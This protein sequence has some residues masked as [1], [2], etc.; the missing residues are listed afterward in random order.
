MLFAKRL[1]QALTGSS[2]SGPPAQVPMAHAKQMLASLLTMAWFVEA[3]DPYTGGHLWRV[4]R[5]AYLLAR[6]AGMDDADAAKVSLGAF[7]HDIGKIGVPDDVLRKPSRL[8]EAEF[9]VIQ[10]HPN[11]GRRMI[12][13][14]PLSGLIEDAVYLH[15]E[16]PDGKGYPL[17]LSGEQIPMM[18]RVVG[19]C[20]AFDAMTSHRPYRPGMSKEAALAIL[21]SARGSQFD[22]KLVGHFL[23]LAE[24]GA[25]E[26][27]L[28]RSDDGIPLQICP[29]CGP[30]LVIQR[31]YLAGRHIYC[32]SCSGQFTLVPTAK[33][34]QAESTG[35]TG[36]AKD[37][38]PALDA[39]LIRR[40]VA[41]A[42]EHL[43]AQDLLEELVFD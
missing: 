29:M 34:L 9:S 13:G 15:H 38:E 3:R 25:L 24:Q 41:Q 10:T 22:D 17:G 33:G 36:D 12:A 31:G 39:D 30:T 40:V 4:S 16:R 1:F 27:V 32:R 21:Q 28:G 42:A 43:A 5:Y 35:V 20:D 8:T 37:L 14:H 11:L 23:V 26:H 18:A 7:L 6:Q 2:S 19:I